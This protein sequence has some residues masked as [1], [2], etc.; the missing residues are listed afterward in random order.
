MGLLANKRIHTC[1]P[2]IGCTFGCRYCFAKDFNNRYH[3][4]KD[5]KHP[6]ER[7][8]ALKS[9]KVGVPKTFF[10]DS[11]SDIADWREDYREDVFNEMR[12]HPQHKYFAL[13]KRPLM[14]SG[15]NCSDMKN[16]W[17]GVSV[18]MKSDVHRIE[19]LRKS[20]K[21]S[22]YCVY[23]EPILGDIGPIN[24]TGIDYIVIGAE[25]GRA[26]GKV[27]PQAS[28]VLSIVDQANKYNVPVMMKDSLAKAKVFKE[29]E[30]RQDHLPVFV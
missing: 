1:N 7:P 21:A 18:T 23:F 24:L 20:V 11:M 22:H 12:K 9:I 13:T 16:V 10:M 8:D 30:L 26:F 17:I 3:F 28:W 5:F 27:K 2:V 25:T 4:V 6:E 14:L 29:E 15:F 19:E